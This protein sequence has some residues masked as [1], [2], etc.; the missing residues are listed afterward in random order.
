MDQ[1]ALVAGYLMAFFAV[2]LLGG[3][4]VA[5]DYPGVGGPV[6]VDMDASNDVALVVAVEDYL[7]L[8]PVPGARETAR[9]WVSFFRESLGVQRVYDLV[10]QEVT[11]ETLNRFAGQAAQDVGEGGTLWFVFV[12]HGA[13]AADGQDGILVGVDAQ[14]NIDSLMARGLGQRDLMDALEGGK[15]GRTVAF[16]D[17]CFSGR[18]GTGSTIVPGLQPVLPVS[19]QPRMSGQTVVLSAAESDQFAGALPGAERPAFSYWMLGAMRGW[20]ALDGEVTAEQA[21]DFTRQK[22]RAVSDRVQTPAGHGALDLVLVSG[23]QEA[24]PLPGWDG[25]RPGPVVEQRTVR[26]EREPVERQARS[27]RDGGIS[28]IPS[29]LSARQELFNDQRLFTRRERSRP[30]FYQGSWGN[31]L[32][33]AEFYR[34]LG[35][36]DLAAQYRAPR[37][38]LGWGTAIG[39]TVAG[40]IIGG[41][42]GYSIVDDAFDPEFFGRVHRADIGA[43]WGTLLGAAIGFPAGLLW[44]GP[45]RHPVDSNRRVLMMQEYNETLQQRLRLEE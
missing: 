12:G 17:A 41:V 22:L 23:V 2:M 40:G 34:A 43:V 33:G 5:S 18:D 20:A 10:D 16:I 38:A 31:H 27:Q 13:P 32:Q 45:E 7:L 36:D 19:H 35:R 37:R 3:Q 39:L 9:D 21:L 15:Q 6:Q 1:R 24:D 4:A 28:S 14:Q 29:S 26:V 8:P 25:R 30:E 11:R 42:I 44:L